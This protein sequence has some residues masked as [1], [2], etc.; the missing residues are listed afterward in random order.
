MAIEERATFAGLPEPTLPW[1]LITKHFL[2]LHVPRTGGQFIRGLCA[3]HLPREWVIRNSLGPHTPYREIAADFAD[4]PMLCFVRNPWD[5]YVSWYHYLTQD[6]PEKR[7]GPMWRVGFGEGRKDFKQA[8]TSACTGRDFGNPRTGPVMAERGVD[9]YSA[10]FWN[11]AGEGVEA[12]RVEVGRF[13][14]LADDFLAFL[15]RHDVPIPEG[16][17]RDLHDVPA[18][19]ASRRGPYRDY[20]D[21][22]LRDLVADRARALIAAFEYSF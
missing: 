22:E 11:T 18:F 19:G 21:D 10:V 15:D 8:V 4:L 20:Y 6:E 16:L 1:M 7:T 14:N 9:H 17:R 13:E 12:G 3:Q 5:W 2:F